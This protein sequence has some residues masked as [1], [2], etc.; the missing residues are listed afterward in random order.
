MNKSHSNMLIRNIF[1]QYG[2]DI[3][4]DPSRVRGERAAPPFRVKIIKSA[5]EDEPRSRTERGLMRYW[6]SPTVGLVRGF[7]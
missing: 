1:Q 3:R 7:N 2:L 5:R 6:Y 4:D